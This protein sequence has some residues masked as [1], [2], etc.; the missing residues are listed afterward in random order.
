MLTRQGKRVPLQDLPFR[1][2]ILLLERPGE[3]VTREEMIAAINPKTVAIHENSLKALMKV[4]KGKFLDQI[5]RSMIEDFKANRAREFKKGSKKR[6]VSPATVNRE[7][8]TLKKILNMA[9]DDELI[10]HNIDARGGMARIKSVKTLE[11]TGI[12][13]TPQ[14]ME[15]QMVLRKKRPNAIRMEFSLQGV[16]GLRAYAG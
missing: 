9:V 7:L 16:T 11:L 2:L 4:F 15:M 6:L 12:V 1:A 8:T 10:Q 3:L 5:P 14:G 13:T